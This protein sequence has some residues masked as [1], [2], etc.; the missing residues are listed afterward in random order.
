[1]NGAAAYVAGAEWRRRWRSALALA[2]AAGLAGAVVMA[3]VAAARRGPDALERFVDRYNTAEAGVFVFGESTS[4]EDVLAVAEHDDDVVAAFAEAYAASAAVEPDGTFDETGTG[5][6]L[7]LG[8]SDTIAAPWVLEGR[9][10]D[11]AAPFELAVNEAF[12]RRTG[13]GPGDRFDIGV[14]S[15]EQIDSAWNE[16]GVVPAHGTHTFTLVGVVRVPTD[17]VFQ[18]DAQPGTVYEQEGEEVYWSAGLYERFDGDLANYGVAIYLDV[19][20][21]ADAEEVVERVAAPFGDEGFGESGS[22]IETELVAVRQSVDQQSNGARALAAVVGVTAAVLLVQAVRRQIRTGLLAHDALGAIGMSSRGRRR[23]ALLWAVP[24]TVVSLVI[25]GVGTVALSALGPIGV[26]RDAEISPGV[27]IDAGVLVVGLVVLGGLLLL[28]AALPVRA[29][30]PAA[31]RRPSLLVGLSPTAATAAGSSLA[32][33]LVSRGNGVRASLAALP[34]AVGAVAAAV[35]F[36]ASLQVATTEPDAYGWTWDLAVANCSEPPCVDRAIE[37]LESNPDVAA[38]TGLGFAFGEVEGVPDRLELSIVEPGLGWAAGSVVRGRPPSGPHDAVL[39]P[40]TAAE[41]GVEIGD[42]VGIGVE[43]GESV[44][45]TVT[46]IFRPPASL[47]EGQDQDDGVAIT[48]AG[49]MRAIPEGLQDL[50]AEEVVSN[51]FLVDLAPDAPVADAERRLEADFGGTVLHPYR[52]SALEAAYRIRALPA[53]LAALVAALGVGALVH[54]AAVAAARRTST[55][56]TLA[57]L[58]CT[59]RQRLG[60]V[61]TEVVLVVAGGLVIGLPLGIALGRLGW[62]FAASG[63]GSSA[64]PR[65]PVLAVALVAVASAGL[66]LLVGSAFGLVG[67]RKSP[68]VGLRTPR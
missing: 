13:L 58:G 4:Y 48:E 49:G 47:H 62:D 60:V 59:R 40:G 61:V 54:V 5:G 65:T 34:I 38:W 10:P 66:A 36:G 26:A 6:P 67:A 35:V 7:R 25:A 63:L 31:P 14:F 16:R 45:F 55:L 27:R 43:G 51:Y 15:S 29:V 19:R 30:E 50:F 11:P 18:N 22:D 23:A 39:G 42:T 24:P 3:A 1:V 68:A 33:G 21:G 12:V 37:R 8:G 17:L 28:A 44:P 46:G 9:M 53:L 41:A 52:P 57:A 32:R 56:A 20:D 2:L 64:A